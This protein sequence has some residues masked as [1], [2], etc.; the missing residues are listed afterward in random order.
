MWVP[1]RIRFHEAWAAPIAQKQDY[2][3]LGP[4]GRLDPLQ[5]MRD[6]FGTATQI[7]ARGPLKRFSGVSSLR[8]GP[9]PAVYRSTLISNA[10]RT[11]EPGSEDV[12]EVGIDGFGTVGE[13]QYDFNIS[14][15]NV[16]GR[17]TQVLVSCRCL[18]EECNVA[19]LV[20]P[21]SVLTRTLTGKI[22]NSTKTCIYEAVEGKF[23]DCHSELLR[24]SA[25]KRGTKP[26][27]V[28]HNLNFTY[29]VEDDV[30][31]DNWR[32]IGQ[33]GWTHDCM[34]TELEALPVKDI[35]N[36]KAEDIAF[37][38]HTTSLHGSHCRGSGNVQ[39]Y[40]DSGDDKETCAAIYEYA[41]A[42]GAHR[43]TQED[44]I[45]IGKEPSSYITAKPPLTTDTE[46]ALSVSAA[47]LGVL[48]AWSMYRR[49]TKKRDA[50]KPVKYVIVGVLKQV[51][52]YALEALP[53]HIALVQEINCRNWN[54]LFAFADGTVTLAEDMTKAQGT[55]KG[56]MLVLVA[57]V[58]EVQYLK[59]KEAQVAAIAAFFDLIAVGIIA[60]TIVRKTRH[61]LN[62]KR[63]NADADAV[64][65]WT[66]TSDESST[67]ALLRRSKRRRRRTPVWSRRSLMKSSSQ[68]SPTV[69]DDDDES[70]VL[71]RMSSGSASSSCD[72]SRGTL[73]FDRL[74]ESTR[75]ANTIPSGAGR[76]VDAVGIEL[77]DTSTPDED[78]EL[79]C[80]Q[81]AVVGSV[82]R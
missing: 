28:R 2:V 63:E 12:C 42:T 38:I 76:D 5:R 48:F 1:D 16:K 13:V 34:D 33:R 35:S 70:V 29:I 62:Q 25:R 43:A 47:C 72:A 9:M 37:N 78:G 54:S 73:A 19:V 80:P 81:D 4:T 10:S 39:Y 46:L 57:V 23:S 49:L 32:A 27:Y 67:P 53:L 58:G 22:V 21:I 24:V 3:A 68:A 15:Q 66:V 69:D 79:R 56:S 44:E 75:V 60:T 6:T 55:A 36:L 65:E 71:K 26:Q 20:R 18:A 59:T 17:S 7:W 14:T 40:R 61:L 74:D 64:S 30:N 82:P 41:A 31:R 45:A 11:C 77:T 51:L 8:S 52:S 50:R